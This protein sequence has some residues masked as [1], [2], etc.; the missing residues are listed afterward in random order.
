MQGNAVVRKVHALLSTGKIVPAKDT[1]ALLAKPPA[2][3]PSGPSSDVLPESNSAPEG[4]RI[5]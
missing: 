4:S 2:P 5:T 3:V 1:Q